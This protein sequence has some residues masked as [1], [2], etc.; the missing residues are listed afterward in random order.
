MKVLE[1]GPLRT[2]CFLAGIISLVLAIAGAILPVL[3]ASPFIIFAAYFFSKSS[4][5]FHDGLRS[6]K[7]TGHIVTEWEDHGILTWPAKIGLT[8]FVASSFGYSIWFDVPGW[9][10]TTVGVLGGVFLLWAWTRPSTPKIR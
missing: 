9:I 4:K 7:Y 5:K 2:L 3:P 6:N 10:P 8:A 1:N